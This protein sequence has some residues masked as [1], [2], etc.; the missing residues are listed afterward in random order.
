MA[1]LETVGLV[2]S[3]VSEAFPGRFTVTEN[4]IP[5]WHR[6]L[7]ELPDDVLLSAVLDRASNGAFPPSPA[8]LRNACFEI[9]EPEALTAG[10]AWAK[11]IATAHRF[12]IGDIPRV[13]TALPGPQTPEEALGPLLWKCVAALGGWR[14]VCLSENEMADRAHFNR[15]YEQLVARERNERRML[16]EVREIRARIQ[17]GET[18]QYLTDGRHDG[19]YDRGEDG[20]R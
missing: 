12:G 16:P 15:I 18:Q 19:V 10:E 5:I 17:S 4:T 1:T 3:V 14:Y 6:I 8:E 13:G 7:E 2:V 20:P 11:I 9:V